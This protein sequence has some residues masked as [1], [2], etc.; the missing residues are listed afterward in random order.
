MSDYH[1]NHKLGSV[2]EF[3]TAEGGRLLVCGYD[4]V[5][6]LDQRPAARQ[7]RE[8]LLTYA[9]SDAFAPKT[10]ITKDRFAKLFPVAAEV[11][12]AKTPPGFEKAV[13]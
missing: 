6:R 12:I 2:F 8:S 1:F 4:L 7:L 10:A 11:A 13:L 3:G 5:S 9:A